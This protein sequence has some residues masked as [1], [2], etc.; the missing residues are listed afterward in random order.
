MK[1]TRGTILDVKHDRKGR[2]TA[3]VNEDFDSEVTTFYPVSTTEP[4]Q[5]C[6]NEWETGENIPCRAS[7][8]TFI[9]IK[10]PS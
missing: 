8:C 5:G 10:L 6:V 9:V 2:F 1:V 4:V 7:L 3:I